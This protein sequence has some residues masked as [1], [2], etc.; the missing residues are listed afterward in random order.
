MSPHPPSGSGLPGSD[1]STPDRD[2]AIPMLTEIVS[3]APAAPAAPQPAPAQ[4]SSEIDWSALEQ[5]IHERVM[6]GLVLRTQALLEPRLQKV[7][8]TAIERAAAV[9]AAELQAHI[10]QLAL[11]IV[12]EAITDEVAR[13]RDELEPRD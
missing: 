8:G 10:A 7:L 11:E 12:G 6:S 5:R 2:D 13:V 1:P 9:L 3:L 4:A